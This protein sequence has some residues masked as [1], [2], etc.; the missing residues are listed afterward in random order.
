MNERENYLRALEF[1]SPEWIPVMFEFTPDLWLHRGATLE[2][3]VLRHPRIFPAYQAGEYTRYALDPFFTAGKLLVDDWGCGWQGAVNGLL[4]QVVEHPLADWTALDSFQPP[5]PATQFNWE[6]LRAQAVEQR[7]RGELVRG[8]L[9]ITQGGFFDRLQFLRGMQNLM[10][11]FMEEPAK[12]DRLIAMLVEYNRR[13]IRLWLDIGVDQIY[14]HGDIGAQNSLMFSP[15]TFK[16]Y[17]KPAYMELFGMCRQAG[18]HV[19]YSSDGRMLEVVDDLIDCGVTL[20]DPQLGPNPLKGLVE[21]Y[22][23]RLC[24]QVDI[25][26]QMLPFWSPK[27]IRQQ[28]KEVV[29][30]MSDSRGGVMLFFGSNADV[31]MSNIEAACLACEEFCCY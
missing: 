23:G 28:V 30:A 21:K 12:L 9:S 17:L 3:I 8:M 11:D 5:D 14:C 16:R 1:R 19:W 25:N 22:K 20:H 2:E 15:K 31:P 4:G 7:R 10:I 18:V 29:E 26:A 13:Y 24:A 6:A 27:E